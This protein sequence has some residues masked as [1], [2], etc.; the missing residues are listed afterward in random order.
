MNEQILEHSFSRMV[1]KVSDYAVFLLDS[2]G[3]IQTWNPAAEVMKGYLKDEAIGRNFSMLYTDEDQRQNHPE[4]NLGDAAENGSFQESGW[5]T[6]ASFELPVGNPRLSLLVVEDN[7]DAADML[8]FLLATMGHQVRLA[9][10]ASA[11]F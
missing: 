7:I 6:A 10:T 3:I 9:H 8:Q 11:S 2:A 5:R 1:E 4:H